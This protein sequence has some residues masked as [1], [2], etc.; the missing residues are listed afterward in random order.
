MVTDAPPPIGYDPTVKQDA[1]D[2][3]SSVTGSEAMTD[4]ASDGSADL[5]RADDLVADADG[6]LHEFLATAARY[7][8]SGA[9]VASAL[10]PTPHRTGS[11]DTEK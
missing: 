1:F 2:T 11:Q 5:P 3:D 6:I 9:A 4:M 10:R 7:V 8:L